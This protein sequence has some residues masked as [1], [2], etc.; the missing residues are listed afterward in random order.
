MSV[1]F[2]RSPM[3]ITFC[4]PQKINLHLDG[5]GTVNLN[6]GSLTNDLGGVDEVIQDLLVD[7]SKSA[8]SWASLLLAGVASR[9]GHD[10]A[11]SNEENVAVRELLLELTGE[12]LLD[13]VEGLELRN[14]DKDNDSL[15]ATTNLNLNL[16]KRIHA[17]SL[18]HSVMTL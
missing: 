14:R 5:L 16:V 9:L 2:I 12:S 4:I 18:F 15:L 8:G 6:A 17:I 3:S 1:T 11:L 13:L 10:T 7:S